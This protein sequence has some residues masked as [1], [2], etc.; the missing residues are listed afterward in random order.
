MFLNRHLSEDQTQSSPILDQVMQWPVYNIVQCIVLFI[1]HSIQLNAGFKRDETRVPNARF[2]VV[3]STAL[4]LDMVQKL[5]AQISLK[6]ILINSTNATILRYLTKPSAISAT[7]SN[8][9]ILLYLL[10][11]GKNFAHF[12]KRPKC[13]NSSLLSILA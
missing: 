7:I 8:M 10:F 11:I 9:T 13:F 5:S 3:L 6:C 1:V 2:P 12:N 4:V